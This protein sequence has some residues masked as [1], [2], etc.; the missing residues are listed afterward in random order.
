[1]KPFDEIYASACLHKGCKKTLEELLPRPLSDNNLIKTPDDRFLSLMSRR[2]FQA[3]LRHEMVNTMW[4]E[5]EKIFKRFDPCY[6][7]MLSDEDIDQLMH[8]SRIIRHMGK[9]QAVRANAKFIIDVAHEVGCFGRFLA[10]WSEDNIVGLWLELKKKGQYLGGFSGP[11]FLRMAGKDTFLLTEDVVAV[12]MTEGV[13]ERVPTA[14]RDFLLAQE[15][16]TV[17]QKESGRHLC[18]ISR[19]VAWA[20]I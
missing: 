1:M 13:L 10:Q 17:W 15:A 3:G 19:I 9:I 20:V 18:Q 16:F 2:I 6:C 14:K 7:A 12:L 11:A 4:P 8:D 5:F